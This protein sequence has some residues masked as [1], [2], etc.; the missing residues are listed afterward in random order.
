MDRPTDGISIEAMGKR[1]E[2]L[3]GEAGPYS[4][5][6]SQYAFE[7][8]LTALQNMRWLDSVW[9]PEPDNV[10]RQDIRQDY[11]E[12]RKALIDY[13]DRIF[14]RIKSIPVQKTLRDIYST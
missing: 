10:F 12:V 6:E 4:P 9:N 7:I 1:I 8:A 13:K 11:Q 14:S 5:E 2:V 3:L